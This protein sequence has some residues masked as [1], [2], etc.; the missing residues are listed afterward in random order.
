MVL[1][2]VLGISFA[3]PL[4]RL[5]A[6]HPLAIAIWRL[7][8]S[9]PLVLAMLLVGAKWREWKTLDKRDIGIALGAG[10]MLAMHFWSWNTSVRLTTVAASA[11]LVNLMPV[12]VAILSVFWLREVPTRL[13][14]AGI[15]IAM[16]GALLVALPDLWSDNTDAAR[17]PLLGDALALLGAVTAALYYLSGRRL[18]QKLDLWPYVALVYSACLVTLLV[19]AVAVDVPLGGQSNREYA[20]FAGL[21]VGPMLLGHTGLNWALKYL[22]AYSVSVA[23]LGEPVGATLL[24]ALLPGIREIPTLWTV[25]AGAV[26]IAGVALALKPP[27]KA[28][29]T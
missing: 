19:V 26:I 28:A 7:V 1:I 5:S 27:A 9:M 22:P 17:N 24:A 25:L 29:P 12:I 6:A 3:A 2:A 20:I 11:V 14:R 18:R 4:I 15:A 13:Q 10:F 21:A 8:F 23:V 16:F